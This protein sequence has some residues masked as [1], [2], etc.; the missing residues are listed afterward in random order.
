[1][2]TTFTTSPSGCS[3]HLA[4]L[5]QM[6]GLL[7]RAGFT[8]VETMEDA[9]VVLCNPIINPTLD[10]IEQ[11]KGQLQSNKL[12]IFSG[13][14]PKN[15]PQ[16]LKN[17]SVISTQQI[18][19]IVELVEEALNDNPIQL[20]DSDGLPHLNLPKIRRN[21]L[22]EILPITRGYSGNCLYCH[23]KQSKNWK[24]YPIADI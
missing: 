6:A 3:A 10:I 21:H 16:K 12:F 7:Q 17:L 20:L 5:E 18:H 1:M 13:C 19:R 15:D 8:R 2:S 14:F 23:S 4:D 24:S 9:Y 11:L 22:I